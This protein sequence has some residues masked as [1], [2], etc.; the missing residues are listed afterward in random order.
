MNDDPDR[1]YIHLLD[2][3]EFRPVFIMGNARS[4][5][6][7]L[8]RLLSLSERFNS[9]TAYHLIRYQT[10]LANHLGGDTERAK[11]N[12]QEMFEALGIGG[13]RFDSV[14][15][16]ADF[17][18]E[19]GFGLSDGWSQ[20]LSPTTLPR[21][22]ELCRKVQYISGEDQPL[23]LKNP[24]DYGNFLY[25]AETFPE[26]R[27]VFIHR[28]PIRVIGSLLRSMRSLLRERNEYHALLAGSYDRLMRSP[29][30]RRIAWWIF[31]S[32]LGTRIVGRQVARAANY[33]V[34]NIHRLNSDRYVCIRY[35]DLC[36]DPRSLI[37]EIMD[38][39]GVEQNTDLAYESLVRASEAPLPD[40]LGA[41]QEKLLRRLHLGR[42]LAYCGYRFDDNGE[43]QTAPLEQAAWGRSA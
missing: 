14:G 37:G 28:S 10:L 13:S 25:L 4:G 33:F 32:S 27:F 38:F 3:V 30:R 22:L 40:R 7:I 1:R 12:L 41:S 16:S 34:R 6:T 18:E 39:L 17:P 9:V 26:A 29:A 31:R 19:Y 24:W 21:F 5:T 2:S 42:Y 15:I 43:V 8:Y 35:E 11:M 23:L 20:R 36:R